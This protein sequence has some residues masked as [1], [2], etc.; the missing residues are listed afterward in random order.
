MSDKPLSD[1]ELLA[2]DL[3]WTEALTALEEALLLQADRIAKQLVKGLYSSHIT[4]ALDALSAVEAEQLEAQCVQHLCAIASPGL[5]ATDHRAMALRVGR[6]SAM[7]GVSSK[8][9]VRRHSLISCVIRSHVDQAA[10]AQA[11]AVFDQ[12]CTL[13]LAWQ[14]EAYGALSASRQAVLLRISRL[15]WEA[16]GYTDLIER[17][18]NTLAKHDEIA[19][20]WVGRPDKR[21]VFRFEAVASKSGFMERYLTE[22]EVTADI[23]IMTDNDSQGQG[24]SSRAWRNAEVERCANMSTDARMKPWRDGALR[25]GFRSSVAIP[26]RQPESSPKAILTLYSPLPGGYS[27]EPQAMFIAQLQMLLGLAIARIESQEGRAGAISYVMRKRWAALIRSDGLQMHYQPLL[28]LRTWQVAKV[29]AL[30]RLKDDGRLLAP[31]EF[32]PALSSDDFLELYVRGLGQA[33]SQRTSW[34]QGGIDLN[35][36]VNLPPSGLGDTRYF[37]ATRQALVEHACPPEALTLEVLET[38]EVPSGVD[39]PDQLAKFAALGVRLAEDDLGSGHSSLSRLRELPFDSIKIDRKIVTMAG[40]DASDVLRFVYQLTRLGHTL[41]KSVIVEGVES[42][43]LL[44]ATAILGVDSAQGYVIAQPMPAAQLTD[45]IRSGSQ[46]VLSDL[47]C[48]Q[49]AL[50]KLAALLVWEERLHLTVATAGLARQAL[51]PR[52]LIES[53]LGLPYASIM[54]TNELDSLIAA[55]ICHGT[56]SMAYAAARKHLVTQITCDVG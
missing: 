38:G 3:A 15:A 22:L 26:L 21:G 6:R 47:S 2:Y 5:C 9:L 34:L 55:A 7:L 29:E 23:A 41:G 14:A 36:S 35:V 33:L 10:H 37:D 53:R 17:V 45:W 1:D 51:L 30:A 40:H 44:E 31:G 48:P 49:S 43:D 54:D 32:F 42:T 27:S 20:S 8:D 56:H 18:V 52:S 16:E 24:P 46:P 12:R 19:G 11:L 39:I 4:S 28:D 25:G 13:D 50:G